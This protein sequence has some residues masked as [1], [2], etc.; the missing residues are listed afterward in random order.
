MQRIIL[1]FCFIAFSV[2]FTQAQN[3]WKNRIQGEGDITEKTI[4]VES[5]DGFTLAISGDLYLRQG[6]QPEIL[7]KAQPNI[8]DNMEFKIRNGHLKITYY[9]PV[10]KSK[11]IRIYMT[12]PRLDKVGISGSGDIESDGTFTDLGDLSLAVSGSGNL[13]FACKARSV[14][15]QISGSGNIRVKGQGD[16][17]NCQ[18]SGSGNVMASDFAVANARVKISGS[19]NASVHATETLEAQVSG[20]GDIRY[21]GQPRLK[22]KTSGSGDISAIR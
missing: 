5:F 17:F 2:S 12:V 19:G 1:S 16:E 3:W 13:T 6:D 15:S 4:A 20:S 11:G 8:I 7:V 21:K 14:S 10:G 22:A 9:R 18:I